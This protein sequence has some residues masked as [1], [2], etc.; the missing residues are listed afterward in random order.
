MELQGVCVGETGTG[1]AEPG[2]VADGEAGG[3][4]CLLV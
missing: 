3:F 4:I 1:T 2:L